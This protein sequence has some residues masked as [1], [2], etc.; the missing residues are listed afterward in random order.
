MVNFPGRNDRRRRVLTE[1]VRSASISRT[2]HRADVS[3]D[4]PRYSDAAGVENHPQVTDFVPRRY[5]TIALLGLFGA[6]ATAVTAAL[7]YFVLPIAASHGMYSSAAFDLTARGNV[8]EWLAAVVLFMASGFCV[9]TYSIRRHRIDDYRGRY[10]VWLGAGLACLILSVNSVTGLHVVLADV[11]TRTTGWSALRDGAAWWIAIAGLPLGWIFVRVL[12][13][14]RECRIAA[15][16]LTGAGVCYG[17]SAASFLGYGPTVDAQVQPIVIA[18]PLL[19]GYWLLFTAIVANARF[20]VLDAQGLVTVRRRTK[21]KRTESTAEKIQAVRKSSPVTTTSSSTNSTVSI[22]RET[23][24]PV[25]TPADSSR[26][27]DGSRFEREHYDAD[28]D[29]ES[30]DGERKLSKSDRKKLRKIKTQGRA[31]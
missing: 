23:L 15:A 21:A 5:S 22:S 17:V 4:A 31:A 9:L 8:T 10:R 20:V 25:K 28:E 13:D 19:L 27:V 26:W 3:D 11:L 14:V 16:L 24:Q 30:S 7:H 6:A 1:E 29:E 12:L 2:A 18:A